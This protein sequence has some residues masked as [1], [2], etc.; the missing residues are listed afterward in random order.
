MNIT[1]ILNYNVIAIYIN[2]K[3]SLTAP[4][5]YFTPEPVDGGAGV[6]VGC[7]V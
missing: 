4:K 6:D 7:E 2:I 1:A 3:G 5:F